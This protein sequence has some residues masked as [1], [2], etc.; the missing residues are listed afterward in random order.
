MLTSLTNT[1]V[2]CITLKKELNLQKKSHQKQ[3]S[4]MPLRHQQKLHQQAAKALLI[5]TRILANCDSSVRISF[6]VPIVVYLQSTVDSSQFQFLGLLGKDHQ[7]CEAHLRKRWLGP[8]SQTLVSQDCLS[9]AST[10]PAWVK[11]L[12]FAYKSRIPPARPPNQP[13]KKP[14]KTHKTGKAFPPPRCRF[15][16]SILMWTGLTSR[17]KKT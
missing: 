12:R 7:L 13:T 6:Y 3:T 15:Y 17:E 1:K 16:W 10:R 5:G 4:K 8:S 2:Y 14:N 11:C 9:F